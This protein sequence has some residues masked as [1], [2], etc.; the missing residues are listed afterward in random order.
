MLLIA[1]RELLVDSGIGIATKPANVDHNLCGTATTDDVTDDALVTAD[2][3]HINETATKPFP[4]VFPTTLL[5]SYK[6]K[7]EPS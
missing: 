7:L 3:E 4:T 5:L 1:V 6:N 2:D